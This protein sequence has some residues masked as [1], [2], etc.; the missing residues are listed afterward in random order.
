MSFSFPSNH[1][2]LY[3]FSLFVYELI[4]SMNKQETHDSVHIN[5][6]R[7]VLENIWHDYIV[8]LKGCYLLWIPFR[9]PNNWF[10]LVLFLITQVEDRNQW[11]EFLIS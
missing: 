4:F 9:E 3:F 1:H 2:A 10:K 7:K 8:E 11:K 5:N 6:N